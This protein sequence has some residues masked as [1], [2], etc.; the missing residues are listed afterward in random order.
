MQWLNPR[1]FDAYIAARTGANRRFTRRQLDEL[2]ARREPKLNGA[3]RRAGAIRVSAV[4]ART[5]F[6][7]RARLAIK[8]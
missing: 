6:G 8:E 1:L 5:R 3:S 4:S 2:S 7:R